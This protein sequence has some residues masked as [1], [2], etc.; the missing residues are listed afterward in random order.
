MANRIFA[1]PVGEVPVKVEGLAATGFGV[2][3]LVNRA[4][5]NTLTLASAA[6]NVFGQE[7][8]VTSE[9]GQTSGLNVNGTYTAGETAEAIQPKSG[10]WVYVRFAAGQNVSAKGLAVTTNGDGT[11]K[12]AATN[13]NE[14]VFGHTEE[15]VGNTTANQLVKV[16][17]A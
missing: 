11:F 8:L 9:L 2:G 5:A 4:T 16:R 17:A 15:I 13:G 12:L 6:A 3:Y 10:Q 1:G 7:F 14:Q